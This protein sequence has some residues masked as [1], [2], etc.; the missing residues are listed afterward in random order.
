[1]Q[2]PIEANRNKSPI[3]LF[4]KLPKVGSNKVKV[5]TVRIALPY[6]ILIPTNRK[7]LNKRSYDDESRN[8]YYKVQELV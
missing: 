8:T 2:K 7:H 3:F 6:S 5:N 1:V 4:A